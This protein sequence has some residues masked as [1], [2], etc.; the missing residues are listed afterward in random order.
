MKPTTFSRPSVWIST[1][2]DWNGR[3]YCAWRP[4]VS[5]GFDSTKE[6]L[7]WLGWPA[8]TPT[9]DEIRAWLNELEATDAKREEERTSA[10]GAAP[11]DIAGGFGPECHLDESD[12]NFQTRTV[13]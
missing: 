2:R 4:D 11:V 13:I 7:R 1:Y 9:G 5:R 6:L 12:P 8:K 10:A 3:H